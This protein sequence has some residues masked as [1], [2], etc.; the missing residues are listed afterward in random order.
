ME[1]ILKLSR[2]L[3]TLK[4]MEQMECEILRRLNWYVHPPTPQLFLSYFLSLFSLKEVEIISL[5]YFMVELS[6]VDY[7]FVSYKPSEI[8]LAALLAAEDTFKMNITKA[9]VHFSGKWPFDAHSRRVLECRDR[10]SLLYKESNSGS[11]K[12]QE[13]IRHGSRLDV[14]MIS[15]VCVT[16]IPKA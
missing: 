13:T 15:P 10:I 5:V 14:R 4:Q 2:G 12:Y 7:F 6:V 8:A 3:F 1:S 9:S 16:S 11:Y